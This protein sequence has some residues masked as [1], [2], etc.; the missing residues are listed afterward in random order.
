MHAVSR[1]I[2]ILS[3]CAVR[4]D[5]RAC[6]FK[7]LNGVSNGI[8][9]KRIAIRI[10]NVA[11]CDSLDQINGSWDTADWLGG[12]RDWRRLGHTYRLARSRIDLTLLGSKGISVSS[13]RPDESGR[14]CGCPF[15][16]SRIIDAIRKLRSAGPPASVKPNRRQAV[17]DVHQK[18][19][20][21]PVYLW[22][23]RSLRCVSTAN[24]LPSTI[25]SLTACSPR[26]SELPHSGVQRRALYPQTHGSTMRTTENPARLV[27]GL[28]DVLS[29]R[30]LSMVP[31]GFSGLVD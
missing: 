27:Q 10:L 3:L 5:R 25:M 7:P 9:I 14:R 8:F 21:P 31:S 20:H 16:R 1:E 30:I 2:V 6:G 11:P 19:H 24:A 18:S 29:L 22:A 23:N 15:D 12:Y 28:P 17:W 26:D 4:D 13:S